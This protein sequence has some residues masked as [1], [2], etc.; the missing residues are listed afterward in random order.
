MKDLDLF[1]GDKYKYSNNILR[2]SDKIEITCPKHGIFLQRPHD[3][4][5]NRNGCPRCGRSKAT[6]TSEKWEEQIKKVWNDTYEYLDKYTLQHTLIRI[7]CH[8]HGI[9]QLKPKVHLRGRGCPKCSKENK[10]H[11]GWSVSK[12]SE[13]SKNSNNFD[14]FKVYIIKCFD[15][16]EEF[17]KI[18]RT[19]L[20]LKCRFSNYSLPYEYDIIKI[21]NFEDA[22]KCAEKEVNVLRH[23]K[24]FKYKPLKV[25]GGKTECFSLECLSSLEAYL[26][27]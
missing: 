18:G 5:I 16:N 14:S 17:I 25:F 19:F 12:W 20:S 15:E 27:L 22:F 24:E 6:K 9:F 11:N 1:I 21:F 13:I 26:K 23:L 10:L 8:Q 2:S 3:H 7:K 4:Y